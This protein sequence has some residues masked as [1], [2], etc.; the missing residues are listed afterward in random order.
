MSAF[1]EKEIAYLHGQRL[2]RLATVNGKGKPHVVPVAFRYDDELDVIDV[3]GHN[4]AQSK[5]W[6][7]A[8]ATGLAAF[9]VD[10]V[11]PGTQWR[12]RGVEVRGRAERLDEGGAEVGPGFAQ[13]L[14]RIHPQRI[15]GWGIDSDGYRPNSRSVG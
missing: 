9:V 15:V 7:D 10:D 14:I 5:K 6:R 2:G 4:F 12:A 13:E 1:T 11:L 8:G 3:G